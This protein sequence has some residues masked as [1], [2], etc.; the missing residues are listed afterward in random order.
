MNRVTYKKIREKI[1]SYMNFEELKA[2]Y[3]FSNWN[4]LYFLEN[5]ITNSKLLM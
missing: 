2:Y 3:Y 4:R 1:R 5:C